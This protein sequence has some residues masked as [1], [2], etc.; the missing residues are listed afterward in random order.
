VGDD[1][2]I[3]IADFGFAKMMGANML[4]QTILGTPNYIAPEMLRRQAGGYATSVD[5]WSMGVILYIL[6]CG[7]PPF[8]DTN[9]AELFRAI[10]AGNFMFHSPDWDCI[11]NEAKDLVSKLLVVDPTKRYTAAQVLEHPWIAAYTPTVVLPSLDKSLVELKRWNAKR[12]FKKAS[13]GV[14]ATLRLKNL[15]MATKAKTA[16]ADEEPPTIMETVEADA[17]IPPEVR[18]AITEGYRLFQDVFHR[19]DKNDDGTLT[20]QEFLEYFGD[21]LMSQEEMTALFNSID[22]DASGR[23][24]STELQTFFLEGLQPYA[25]IFAALERMHKS[26][27]TALVESSEVYDHQSLFHQYRTRFF[28]QEAQKQLHA[29]YQPIEAAMTA[30]QTR[31]KCSGASKLSSREHFVSRKVQKPSEVVDNF[32]TEVGRLKKFVDK[33]DKELYGSMQLN[34]DHEDDLN[35]SVL[36]CRQVTIEPEHMS[37]FTHLVS[38]YFR[39][40]KLRSDSLHVQLKQLPHSP[41][42]FL[43]YTVWV[44]E[45]ALH[46]HYTSH[47]WREH[48]RGCLPLLQQPET[49][50]TVPCPR[51]W[52]PHAP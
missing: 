8:Y 33:I 32:K 46:T 40:L 11:S 18:D 3:K 1:A 25:S 34:V 23:I 49:L 50:N 24:D 20:N 21:N 43:V 9:Q 37:T 36:L 22:T 15:V 41:N 45:Q 19:A 14:L 5:M 12:K 27:F 47:L 51:G 29:L 13:Q 44:N 35:P 7:Y 16:T 30:M 6:L 52:W 10:I 26:I 31:S 38:E 39:A 2:P 4:T 42:R 48:Q 17:E 28:F